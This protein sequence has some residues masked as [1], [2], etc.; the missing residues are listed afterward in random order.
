MSACRTGPTETITMSVPT[1][2][3]LFNLLIAELGEQLH[4]IQATKATLVDVSHIL[5]DLVISERI[6]AMIF[7][8]FQE[9]SHWRE[10]TAR[11]RELAGVAHQICIF[12][13]GQLPVEQDQRQIHVRLH[14]PDPLRQEWFLLVLTESFA[15]VLCGRD[16]LIAVP[17]ESDRRFDTLWTFE[18][19]LITRTLE[20]LRA[21]VARERPDR[22]ADLD[23]AMAR[24]PPPAPDARLT[25]LFTTRLIHDLTQQ[26]QARMHLER[27]LAY[28]SRL[29][30]LGQILSGVAHELNNPLQSILGFASLIADAPALAQDASADAHHIVAAAERA[31]Q[32]VQS[33]LQLARPVSL[34]FAATDLAELAAQTLIFVRTDLETYSIA[35]EVHAATPLPDALVNPVRIQQLLINLLTN[36]IQALA[37]HT[38]PRLIRIEVASAPDQKVALTVHDNGPGIPQH[39]HERIFEPFFTTKPVGEGTGL[40]LSIARTIVQEHGGSIQI[41]S[42]PGQGTSFCMHFPTATGVNPP[43]A[44]SV[45]P[46]GRGV[47]LVIDDDPQ[48]NAL[49]CRVLT[50][51][52]YNVHAE[53]SP[54]E[55][56]ERL[57]HADY[58][59]IICDLL[60]PGM[61]GS[62]LYEE[63]MQV[64]PLLAQRLIFVTG[65]AT[66]P[67]TRAFLEGTGLPYLLKPFKPKQL[68]A[69]LGQ[70]LAGH[71]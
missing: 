67:A 25:T 48:V 49:I 33:L 1:P 5:E 9:S 50:N 46:T 15:A 44:E 68:L 3:S 7:T 24:F 23:A 30:A 11:Y 26:H 60:M 4:P 28:D 37:R 12:A 16:C 57:V 70:V 8:G 62:E 52:G 38:P 42:A 53:V 71:E 6:P 59:A 40:G 32:I 13:G 39:L 65:D 69:T 27:V 35:I 20:L 55:A 36:A 14:G 41:E 10:E 58:A 47:I 63:L 61:N 34:G 51:A 19:A 43:A 22:L 17:S 29:R 66:R 2:L 45:P 54:L 31:Q 64:N 56:R 18:P 21:V